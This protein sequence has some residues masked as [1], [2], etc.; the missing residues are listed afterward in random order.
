M[1]GTTLASCRAYVFK[2]ILQA[3]MHKLT[4]LLVSFQVLSISS[5]TTHSSV[6]SLNV[7]VQY[8]MIA[9]NLRVFLCKEDEQV[10]LGGVD[11]CMHV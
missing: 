6:L 2:L 8:V 10:V 4:N 5:A 7:G 1:S 9:G 3:R 11:E